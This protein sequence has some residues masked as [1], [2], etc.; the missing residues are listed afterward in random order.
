MNIERL[1]ELTPR[2]GCAWPQ[3]ALAYATNEQGL[4][5]MVKTRNFGAQTIRISSELVQ[6][7]QVLEGWTICSTPPVTHYAAGPRTSASL[8]RTSSISRPGR[9]SSSP[10]PGQVQVK[11]RQTSRSRLSCA[12]GRINEDSVSALR[13]PVDQVWPSENLGR[14]AMKL[15]FLESRHRLGFTLGHHTRVF[16]VKIR[17][18]KE[19]DVPNRM[20]MKRS[21]R[22]TWEIHRIIFSSRPI[23]ANFLVTRAF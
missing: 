5:S 20:W 8:I 15:L 19:E 1:S 16:F 14:F 17:R 4:P 7:S 12:Q 2:S 22:H 21:T 10:D 11:V 6:S 3:F 23:S 9:S 13:T 18:F